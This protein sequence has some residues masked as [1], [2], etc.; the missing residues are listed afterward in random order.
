MGVLHR[1]FTWLFGSPPPPRQ[2]SVAQAASAVPA[3]RPEQ[4]PSSPKQV[5]SKKRKH[6]V[7]DDS[8]ADE[9]M[10]LQD[11]F[12]LRGEA[13]SAMPRPAVL[14]EVTRTIRKSG[15]DD[16]DSDEDMDIEVV[17]KDDFK[18]S[19]EAG[20]VLVRLPGAD[21]QKIT[22]TVKQARTIIEDL[23]SDEVAKF[24]LVRH[25]TNAGYVLTKNNKSYYNFVEKR[26]FAM[27]TLTSWAPGRPVL[28]VA[29]QPEKSDANILY[30]KVGYYSLQPLSSSCNPL[31]AYL[32][33]KPMYL[34]NSAGGVYVM[35]LPS[36]Y[37]SGGSSGA[38]GSCV[39]GARAAEHALKQM[40]S[41]NTWIKATPSTFKKELFAPTR[42]N[43]WWWLESQDP[44]KDT[45]ESLT[46]ALREFSQDSTL[47][48][49]KA[50]ANPKDEDFG[51]R[52][53]RKKLVP[54][55]PSGVVSASTSRSF[56]TV[57]AESEQVTRTPMPSHYT[58]R[59]RLGFNSV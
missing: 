27:D 8:D 51:V 59:R 24:Q 31:I 58:K 20:S 30:A 6:D 1:I 48:P 18:F 43:E 4:Q 32:E 40:I 15:V 49:M 17:L 19:V 41:S 22:L 34:T 10:V 52:T 50:V 28:Y 38:S 11:D 12:Q 45:V 42:Q 54:Y 35:S 47:G 13:G 36:R 7:D 26:F 39:S 53:G 14:K 33:K 5:A 56:V 23:A 2:P 21:K 46:L 16:D 3:P 25:S 57:L 37:C 9:E 55:K 29:F 44:T